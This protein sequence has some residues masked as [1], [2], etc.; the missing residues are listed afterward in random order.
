MS[1]YPHEACMYS[2]IVCNQE[3]NWN[4]TPGVRLGSSSQMAP[5]TIFMIEK[6]EWL[7]LV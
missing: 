1:G 2:I 6:L 4:Y 3:Q 7:R 5:S